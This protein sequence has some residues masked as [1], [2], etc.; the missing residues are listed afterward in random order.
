MQYFVILLFVINLAQG[1][2][3]N[4]KRKGVLTPPPELHANVIVEDQWKEAFKDVFNVLCHNLKKPDPFFRG[5]RAHPGPPYKAAYLWDTAFITQIWLHWDTNIAEEL[6][7]YI[8]KFQ[9]PSGKIHHAVVEIAIKP[10]AYSESQPP[11]LSWAS[12]RIFKKS[13]NLDFLKAVYPKLKLYHEWLLKER[14][15]QDGLF[16][17]AHPYESG[18]DNSPRFS[19]RS[20]NRFEDTTKMAAVDM[21]AYMALSMESLSQIA[22]AL[23]REDDRKVFAKQYTKLKNLMNEKL[24]DSSRGMYFDWS[25]KKKSFIHMETISNLTPMVAGIP[26]KDQARKMMDK[27]IDPNY[28]NTSIPFPSVARNEPTFVKDMWRGPV[29]IN[30]AYLGVL[31][32]E[33]YGNHQEARYLARKIVKG[34]YETWKNTGKFYEFYDPDRF[35]IKELHRKKGNLWKKITLGSKPVKDF[36]GWTGLANSLLIEFGEEFPKPYPKGPFSY[37]A[38]PVLLKV[39]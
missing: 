9:K 6:I 24:W 21:S 13:Q 35:D 20:E 8:L 16:F 26:D 32:V 38:P 17:W 12:W 29:W 3:C 11:L 27:I 19:T 22:E 33:R 10:V 14:Q 4:F 37:L 36:V 1:K 34:I 31:G 2:E 30:M 39:P 28:Y 7:H 15:H 23:G 18:I 25:Y 5:Y